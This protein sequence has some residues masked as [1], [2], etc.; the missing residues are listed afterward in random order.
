M[1]FWDT[2][3]AYDLASQFRHVLSQKNDPKQIATKV[4]KE[5]A[6]KE[7][8]EMF[9]NGWMYKATVCET[10]KEVTIVFVKRI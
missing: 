2:N 7:V 10:E 6:E 5:G 8:N 9:A 4:K 1:N 3:A